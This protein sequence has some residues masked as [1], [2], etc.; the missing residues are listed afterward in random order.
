T[1]FSQAEK[2]DGWDAEGVV[3][4]FGYDARSNLVEIAENLGKSAWK[5]L[6]RPP[7]YVAAGAPRRRPARVKRQVI[8]RREFLQLELKSEQVAE[9]DYRPTAC[10][11]SSRMVVVRENSY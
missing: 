6:E 10:E 1:A 7:T 3:F 2:L 4:Q 8:R 11:K 9:F 5:K